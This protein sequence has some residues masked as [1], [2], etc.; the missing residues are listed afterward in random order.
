MKKRKSRLR[1]FLYIESPMWELD[2]VTEW[3]VRWEVPEPY[4][5]L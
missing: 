4:Q 5:A 2:A 3:G 1:T